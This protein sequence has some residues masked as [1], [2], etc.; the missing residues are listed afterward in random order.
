MTEKLS[1]CF[2]AKLG[3]RLDQLLLHR[4]FEMSNL[5]FYIMTT[6]YVVPFIDNA[7]I[8]S[9]NMDVYGTSLAYDETCEKLVNIRELLNDIGLEL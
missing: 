9:A 6:G 3:D 7:A 5:W 1:V 8:G 4:N 2:D